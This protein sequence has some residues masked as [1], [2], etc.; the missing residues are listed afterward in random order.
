MN[1]SDRRP[2]SDPPRSSPAAE[3]T[4][5]ESEA[6]PAS[7]RELVRQAGTGDRASWNA[8][9]ARFSPR[10]Q[11]LAARLLVR[12]GPRIG[13]KASRPYLE[14]LVQ[15]VWQ[16][17][18]SRFQDISREFDR[19]KGTLE[20]Y[21]M[22]IARNQIIS[23]LRSSSQRPWTMGDDPAEL[24]EPAAAQPDPE[25]RAHDRQALTQLRACMEQELGPGEIAVLMRVMVDEENIAAVAAEQGVPRNTL[26]KR[27]SRARQRLRDCLQRLKLTHSR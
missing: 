16:H 17:I 4:E 21:L 7:E 24:P 13:V 5:D 2:S 14:D 26:D 27:I 9:F 22:V 15:A 19:D 6:D 23:Q 12:Y 25:T 8:L 3:V 20:A 10:F 18:L 11:V 1:P